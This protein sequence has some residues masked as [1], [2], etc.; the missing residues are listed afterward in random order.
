MGMVRQR[1]EI[2]SPSDAW[3][4]QTLSVKAFYLLVKSLGKKKIVIFHPFLPKRWLMSGILQLFLKGEDWNSCCCRTEFYV[5]PPFRPTF[6]TE[7]EKWQIFCHFFVL[8]FQTVKNN[9]AYVWVTSWEMDKWHNCVCRGTDELT[10]R[11]FQLACS[12][13]C[14]ISIQKNIKLLHNLQSSCQTVSAT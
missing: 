1:L 6:L 12:D 2:V 9:K 13:W 10:F 8:K 11:S 3:Q 5:F 7:Q 4:D 14:Q